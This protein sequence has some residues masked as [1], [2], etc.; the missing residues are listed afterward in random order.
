[1]TNVF[2]GHSPGLWVPGLIALFANRKL[3]ALALHLLQ[4][5]RHYAWLIGFLRNLLQ[6][7][8]TKAQTV[9]YYDFPGPVI[10]RKVRQQP[11]AAVAFTQI[12]YHL[13]DEVA[14]NPR[15]IAEFR[16]YG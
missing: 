14:A 3:Q 8:L 1:M 2:Y 7:D 6:R 5:S 16:R 13:P 10:D 15:R 11:G 9:D 12:T 4:G